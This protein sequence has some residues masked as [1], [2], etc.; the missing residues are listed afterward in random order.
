MK[1]KYAPW[2]SQSLDWLLT[3]V[4]RARKR[5]ATQRSVEANKIFANLKITWEKADRNAKQ[6]YWKRKLEQA[7]NSSIWNI[8]KG[9][10]MVH[11]NAIPDLDGAIEFSDK[12]NKLRTTLFPASDGAISIIP[13]N[14]VASQRGLSGTFTF[15]GKSEVKQVFRAIN[16]NSAVGYDRITY[17]NLIHLNLTNPD[18][19]PHIATALLWF[20]YHYHKWKHAICVVIPKQGKSSYKIAKSYCQISLLPRL[21]KIIEKIA[22]TQISNTGTICSAIS[23][24]QFRNKDSVTVA[25]R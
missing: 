23:Q 7:T 18:I 12:C 24:F 5:M 6:R 14:F 1:T 13:E 16:Q 9:H 8:N 15:L 25:R 22:A 2:W 19:I 10:T 17:A 3:K 11:S 21:G 20:G 4:K